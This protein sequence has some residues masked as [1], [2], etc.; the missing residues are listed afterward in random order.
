VQTL[1]LNVVDLG[2]KFIV[3]R[4]RGSFE[5][6]VRHKASIVASR[7]V[8]KLAL[9]DVH[10]GEDFCRIEDEDVYQVLNSVVDLLTKIDFRGIFPK[11]PAADSKVPV[12]FR[13][14][15]YAPYRHILFLLNFT[16]PYG[17]I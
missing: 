6:F 15:G 16:Y 12:F 4:L 2:V 1:P 3:F 17:Y 8:G 13:Q 11:H 7:E 9:L 10:F 14:S 5:R